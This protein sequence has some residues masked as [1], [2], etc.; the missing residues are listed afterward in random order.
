M[1]AKSVPGGSQ[2]SAPRS[3]RG[4]H[5]PG[6]AAALAERGLGDEEAALQRRA[7]ERYSG[8][9]RASG[10]EATVASARRFMAR[11]ERR[12]ELGG[13]D[14]AGWKAGL[15]WRLRAAWPR[16]GG[17]GAEPPPRQADLR[18]TDGERRFISSRSPPPALR[19]ACRSS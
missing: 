14:L 2:L 11:V 16:A 5:S 18:K 9:C 10:A 7:I 3:V 13:G 12:G 1:R 17:G 4:L 8:C 6:W 19:G 15:N